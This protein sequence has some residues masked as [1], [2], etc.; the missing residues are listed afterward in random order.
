[1][2]ELNTA[3]TTRYQQMEKEVKQLSQG[4]NFK[5]SIKGLS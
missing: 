2:E 1:M 3:L 4:P 5:A